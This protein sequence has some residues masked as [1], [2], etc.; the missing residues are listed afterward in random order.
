VVPDGGSVLVLAESYFDE[1]NTHKGAERLCVGG[2][3][4]L[5]D[6]AEQQAIRWA[7]LLTKYKLPYFH[8]VDCAHH[9]KLYEHLSAAECD[10]A[11]R[12]A[13]QIIKDTASLGICVTVLEA[14]YL[15]I[16]PQLKFF[17][18]AYD[19][20]ARDLIAG[21]TA[22]ISSTS[23]K[24]GMH[25]FFEE[26]TETEANASHCIMQM[27]KEPEIRKESCYSGHS[28]I[29]KI[30]S[31]GFRQQIFWHGTPGRIA[32]EHCEVSQCERISRAFAKSRIAAFT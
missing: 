12:E 17:G 31:P 6:A 10:Q 30:R 7:D 14:D 29:P 11:A 15:E 4:F 16:I 22:W 8:M 21:V 1:T 28:F 24:G 23:F 2:Y 32:N 13:I 25:Y 26:G 19:A 18:S 20:C 3:I 5:K 27:M 9:S